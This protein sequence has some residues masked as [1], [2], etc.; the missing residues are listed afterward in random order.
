MHSK[1]T[2]CTQLKHNL[3]GSSFAPQA[4]PLEVGARFNVCGAPY[5]LLL[6]LLPLLPLLPLDVWVRLLLLI[7]TSM[8]L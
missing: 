1:H 6:L 3:G 2:H 4:N 5:V 7:A 8:V